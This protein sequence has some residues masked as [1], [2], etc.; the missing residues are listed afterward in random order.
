MVTLDF[1]SILSQP[2]MMFLIIVAVDMLMV[3]ER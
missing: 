2:E 1:A 3:N